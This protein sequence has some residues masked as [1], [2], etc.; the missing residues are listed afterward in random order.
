MRYGC[1]LRDGPAQKHRTTPAG[2]TYATPE[3]PAEY[4]TDTSPIG[5]GI[6]KPMPVETRAASRNAPNPG[7]D[8]KVERFP[9]LKCAVALTPTD[10]TVD[11]TTGCCSSLLI[12]TTTQRN[13]APRSCKNFTGSGDRNEVDAANITSPPMASKNWDGR[14]RFCN[15]QVKLTAG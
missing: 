10:D 11:V 13:H 6:A 1:V 14:A 9:A 7:H 15:T 2:D 4:V 3:M 12:T 8:D 5:V